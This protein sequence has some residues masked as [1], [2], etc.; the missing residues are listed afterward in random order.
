M[1]RDQEKKYEVASFPVSPLRAL[2]LLF[3]SILL[4]LLHFCIFFLISYLLP[5]SWG[6]QL[7]AHELLLVPTTLKQQLRAVGADPDEQ[8]QGRAR[9]GAKEQE[10][11]QRQKEV[12]W[13][14]Q[15]H[16]AN[17]W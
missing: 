8:E 1:L 4:F 10:E 6:S 2:K 16:R 7:S 3:P 12:K 14:I 11:K 15:G 5:S 9:S 13:L 17:Q